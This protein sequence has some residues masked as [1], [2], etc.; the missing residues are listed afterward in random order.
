MNKSICI[1]ISKMIQY[2]HRA[3]YYHNNVERFPMEANIGMRPT[4]ESW[5]IYKLFPEI[6]KYKFYYIQYFNNINITLNSIIHSVNM[7]N[8]QYY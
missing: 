7:S 5:N 8:I 4:F 1:F 6:C 3:K 2:I